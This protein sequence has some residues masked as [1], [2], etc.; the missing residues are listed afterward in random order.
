MT[1][2][3]AVVTSRDGSNMDYNKLSLPSSS[4]D[5]AGFV[6]GSPSINDGGERL[7]TSDIMIPMISSLL[8]KNA[9]PSMG[10]TSLQVP[11]KRKR[12]RPAEVQW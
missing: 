2:L 6:R 8:S 4:H 9:L 1:S 3:K 5:E 11:E 12:G 7:V 10:S